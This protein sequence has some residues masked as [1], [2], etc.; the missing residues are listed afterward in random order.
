MT[1]VVPTFETERLVLRGW[2]ESDFAPLSAF[3]A[4]DPASVFVGGPRR[5]SDV[6]MWFMA[7]F[8][9]WVM[10]GYGTFVIAERNGADFCGWCGVNH[11]VDM[12]EPEVQWALISAYRGKGYMTEAGRSALDFVFA[13]S[14][15]ETL[16]TTIHPKNPTSQATAGRLNGAPTGERE[17]DE[18]ETVDVWRFQRVGAAT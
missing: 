2:A 13:A 11:Y 18:G 14:G 6:V 17:V 9:Q 16:R 12:V 5:G 15:R 1:T 8:G 7:R 4:D 3:Y 10:R